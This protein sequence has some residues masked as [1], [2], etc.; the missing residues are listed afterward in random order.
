MYSR[1]V[2][3]PYAVADRKL[4]MDCLCTV[5]P[6]VRQNSRHHH[7]LNVTHVHVSRHVAA[8]RNM[9]CIHCGQSVRSQS[10]TFKHANKSVEQL[11]S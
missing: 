8:Q 2:Q 10:Q 9:Y 6:L 11:I 3:R 5:I 4:T 1:V 7:I